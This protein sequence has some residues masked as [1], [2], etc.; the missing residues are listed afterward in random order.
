MNKKVGIITITVGEMLNRFNYGNKLQNYAM[1]VKLKDFGFDSE[2]ILYEPIIPEYTK[3]M[4]AKTTKYKFEF[5]QFINDVIRITKRK[6]FRKKIDFL[7]ELRTQKFK[8]FNQKNI[9]FS[10][11]D[12]KHGDD[13]SELL[14]KY[15][16]FI[17]GSD[18]IWNPYY[19]GFNSFYF[20]DF[21]PD[22]RKITY[23]PSFGVSVIPS[24]IKNEYQKRLSSI[25]Y[26][27][28]REDI[29][30]ELLK[31]EFG[32]DAQ[33]VCD[34]VFLLGKEEWMKICSKRK[35]KERY[36]AVYLLGKMSFE[37]KKQILKISKELNLKLIDIYTC[38][39]PNSQFAGHNEFLSL[40]YNCEFLI[41]DSFHGTAFSIIFDKPVVIVDR[42][43]SNKKSQ[44][45]MNSRIDSILRLVDLN[46]KT[47]IENIYKK[48][49]E[50]FNIKYNRIKL[51]ELIIKSKNYLKMSLKKG[52]KNN[53]R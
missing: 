7:N 25:K 5:N 18:Q 16:L 10:K 51:D 46:E 13:L 26:L 15:D 34:P 2:T 22:S 6:V 38:D 39:N 20:M 33:F 24:E 11:K 9:K 29:G 31:K 48:P 45:K 40:I 50:I 30:K 4:Q 14:K 19:E 49:R 37:T 21:A 53:E 23:A 36:I 12:Y 44:Y 35:I 47:K 3:K 28:I 43:A 32:L 1:Q 42:N 41:T 8:E 52:E 17:A 27:S